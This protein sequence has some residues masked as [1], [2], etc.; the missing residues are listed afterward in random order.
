MSLFYS[1]ILCFQQG[2]LIDVTPLYQ[3]GS[4]EGDFHFRKIDGPAI[5]TDG[6]VYIADSQAATVTHFDEKGAFAGYIGRRGQGPGEFAMPVSVL[7]QG[8]LI[9]I[10]DP[11]KHATLVFDRQGRYV[12]DLRSRIMNLVGV[13]TAGRLIGLEE[14]PGQGFMSATRLVRFDPRAQKTEPLLTFK[15]LFL[16]GDWTPPADGNIFSQADITPRRDI[17]LVAGGMV[18]LTSRYRYEIFLFDENGGLRHTIKRA[19]ANM[20][21]RPEEHSKPKVLGMGDMNV[22][23]L[24]LKTPDL[25][26]D[27]LSIVATTDGFWAVT[28][29]LDKNGNRVIHRYDH[30]GHEQGERLFP[31]RYGLPIAQT[32]GS[33]WSIRYDREEEQTTLHRLKQTP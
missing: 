15:E 28:S 14:Q 25:E 12:E 31:N 26:K 29:H 11:F 33:I 24:K 20:P 18:A 4:P 27:I 1:L 23:G 30:D 9:Y 5:T 13:D 2:P 21:F 3:I 19:F 8:D 10:T 32:A 6:H 7:I 22:A 16:Q 17:Y